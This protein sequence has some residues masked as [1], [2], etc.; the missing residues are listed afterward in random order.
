MS[1]LFTWL[2]NING[3]TLPYMQALYY[4]G[5]VFLN[6]QDI[7]TGAVILASSGAVIFFQAEDGIRVAHV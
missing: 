6:M 7:F 5:F 3:A 4:N 2:M 1:H